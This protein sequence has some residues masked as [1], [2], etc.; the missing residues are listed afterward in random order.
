MSK[1]E[2]PIIVIENTKDRTI[3]GYYGFRVDSKTA[4]GRNEL[5]WPEDAP[6]PTSIV[7]EAAY[8]KSNRYK[9]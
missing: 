2:L 7:I 3:L 1:S 4:D 9:H 6:S 5:V 8:Q